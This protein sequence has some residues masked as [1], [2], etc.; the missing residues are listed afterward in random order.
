MNIS[1]HNRQEKKEQSET[2][3]STHSL[4]TMIGQGVFKLPGALQAQAQFLSNQQVSFPPKTTKNH[5]SLQLI[6]V[7]KLFLK[8]LTD[9][10]PTR[11]CQQESS[12]C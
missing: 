10:T 8:F 11:L 6:V 1:K 7:M 4:P 9:A 2:P 3:L 5:H 12:G